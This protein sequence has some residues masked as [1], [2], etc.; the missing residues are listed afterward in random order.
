MCVF[1]CTWCVGGYCYIEHVMCLMCVWPCG[2]CVWQVECVP[3][4]LGGVLHVIHM[5]AG[6]QTGLMFA[7]GSVCPLLHVNTC[8]G[9]RM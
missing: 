2:V 1:V 5:G 3:G 9:P 6:T 7:S 8:P 4:V